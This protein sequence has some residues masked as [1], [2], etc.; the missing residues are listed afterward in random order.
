MGYNPNIMRKRQ[1]PLVEISRR[2]LL[3]GSAGVF[4]LPVLAGCGG[5]GTGIGSFSSH[6]YT[7]TVILP[8]GI[9]A[10]SVTIISGLGQSPI[11]AGSFAVNGISSFP[12]LLTVMDNVTKKVMMVGILDPAIGAQTFDSSSVAAALIF[13]ALGGSQLTSDRRGPFL[14]MIKVNSATTTLATTIA[15]QMNAD[16]FALLDGDATIKSAL[17]TAVAAFNPPIFV[18]NRVRSAPVPRTSGGPNSTFA[19]PSDIIEGSFNVMYQVTGPSAPV[20]AINSTLRETHLSVFYVGK[21]NLSGIRMD[22]SS[23]VAVSTDHEIPRS[24][25]VDAAGHLQFGQFLINVSP[26]SAAGTVEADYFG[27]VRLTP[28]FDSVDPTFFTDSR[29]IAN[30]ASWRLTLEDMY[31]R[32]QV[33]VAAQFLIE[34]LGQGAI[35]DTG[36]TQRAVQNFGLI[37][38]Q[39]AGLIQTA[40]TGTGLIPSTKTFLLNASG[41]DSAALAYISA[42]QSSFGL[43]LPADSAVRIA[44]LRGTILIFAATGILD[45][46][47]LLGEFVTMLTAKT[48]DLGKTKSCGYLNEAIYNYATVTINPLTAQYQPGG[49]SIGISIP[50]SFNDIAFTLHWVL[51]GTNASMDD[52]HG[53]S[54]T[55]FMTNQTTVSV[56]TTPS[57]VGNLTIRCDIILKSSGAIVGTAT[58]TLTQII[59][60]PNGSITLNAPQQVGVQSNTGPWTLYGSPGQKVITTPNSL[61]SF[62]FELGFGD[63]VYGQYPGSTGT[64]PFN[65]PYATGNFAVHIT[66]HLSGPGFSQ[67][68]VINIPPN[69]LLIGEVTN[70]AAAQMHITA[71]NGKQISFSLSCTLNNNFDSLFTN[72]ATFALT[73]SG[74]FVLP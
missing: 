35:F 8:T 38:T 50:T 48:D 61:N 28:L 19:F 67:G 55:D 64:S 3:I 9:A 39:E 4:F 62:K 49:P 66:T 59:P 74:T 40:R 47:L 23:A 56:M 15:I 29:Y 53:H 21:T 26:H 54:G 68:Q 2:E 27:F 20:T 71:I 72:D 73:S 14:T 5:S 33:Q 31:A 57:T 44:N 11:T 10:S 32:A 58:S 36:S 34:G 16:P 42:I 70:G 41:S 1:L 25:A 60:P 65:G 52:G 69:G 17:A 18:A 45:S 24:S 46:S 12:T 7:G 37:G 13:L 6:L 22:L 43:T 30:V 51:N 63:T